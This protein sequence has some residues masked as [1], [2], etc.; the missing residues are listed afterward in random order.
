MWRSAPAQAPAS[1]PYGGPLSEMGIYYQRDLLSRAQALQPHRGC[2]APGNRPC[3]AVV[4][5]W[6]FPRVRCYRR[7]SAAFFRTARATVNPITDLAP[8]SRKVLAH[9][10][11]VAPEVITSSTSKT[12]KLSTWLPGRVAKAPRTDSHRSSKLSKC[13]SGRGRILVS[14]TDL[15]GSPS[16]LASGLAIGAA[17]L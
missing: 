14:K 7:C 5:S 1:T 17:W 11:N 8:A 9:E 15:Y 6:R 2:G 10:S 12:R 4:R 3:L 13:L 16:C